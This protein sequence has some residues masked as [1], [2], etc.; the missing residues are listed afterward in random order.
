MK[1]TQPPVQCSASVQTPK[2]SKYLQRLC[3][4]FAHKV[5]SNW[6][7]N[8]GQV[9]FVEGTCHLKV[10]V[11]SLYMT[12]SADTEQELSEIVDTMDRHFVRFAKAE[13]LLL[14]WQ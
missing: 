4:H 11:N 9:T 7:E 8:Q 1:G 12:C 2:G 6:D 5:E 14:T 10:D 13:G 3:K